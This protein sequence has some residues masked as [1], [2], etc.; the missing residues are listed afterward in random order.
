MKIIIKESRAVKHMK[1]YV[2]AF[3]PLLSEPLK[4]RLYKDII[5]IPLYFQYVSVTGTP[6]IYELIPTKA[7]TSKYSRFYVIL[8]LEN[9]YSM[10]G[11]DLFEE[12]FRQVHNIDL[13]DEGD[14]NKNWNF[15]DTF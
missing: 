9:L 14:F 5:G 2:D 10:F 12:Y 3:L 8:T 4:K 15:S 11:K 1:A 6:I 7:N 13:S